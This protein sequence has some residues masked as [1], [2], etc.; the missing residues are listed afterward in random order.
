[1]LGG[2]TH[3]RVDHNNPDPL[4]RCDRCGFTYNLSDLK[5]QMEWRGLSLADT[6]WKV[7][8]RC[9]DQ[10]DPQLRTVILKPDPESVIEARPTELPGEFEE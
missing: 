4:A 6:G 1:M 3:Y 7:C 2:G 10:P 5:P 9:L 8:P